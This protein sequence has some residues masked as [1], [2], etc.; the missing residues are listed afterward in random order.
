MSRRPEGIPSS[1]RLYRDLISGE[2]MMID[3]CKALGIEPELYSYLEETD[4]G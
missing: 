4:E 1:E 2:I 3:V